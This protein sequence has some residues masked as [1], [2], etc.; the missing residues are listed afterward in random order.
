MSLRSKFLIK[1]GE[2]LFFKENEPEMA[3]KMIDRAI[4]AD[5]KDWRAYILKSSIL[6]RLGRPKDA[7]IVL[8]SYTRDNPE[9]V[10]DVEVVI[11]F[12]REELG[13][14]ISINNYSIT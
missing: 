5:S 14:Y 10:S 3:F 13:E 7:L 2:N 8:E 9:K 6:M 4:K 11:G 1:W 12:L